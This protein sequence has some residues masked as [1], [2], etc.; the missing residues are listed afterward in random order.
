[1]SESKKK[2]YPSEFKESAIKLVIESGKTA[3]EVSR[4]LGINTN[5]MNTWIRQRSISKSKIK[6]TRE[7]NYDFDEIKKLK[8]TSTRRKEVFRIH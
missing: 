5:T 7:I 3:A 1:M 6:P 8:K 4:E 2:L